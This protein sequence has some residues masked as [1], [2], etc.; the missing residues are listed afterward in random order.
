MEFSRDVCKA[1]LLLC[2]ATSAS[3]TT[4]LCQVISERLVQN[5]IPS[6]EKELEAELLAQ[7]VPEASIDRMLADA[8][9]HRFL[10]EIHRALGSRRS[11]HPAIE[12]YVR[13]FVSLRLPERSLHSLE[14][15]RTGRDQDV[16]IVVQ[17]PRPGEDTVMDHI[18]AQRR[19]LFLRAV[20][21]LFRQGQYDRSLV[22]FPSAENRVTRTMEDL[23]LRLLAAGAFLTTPGVPAVGFSPTRV[24]IAATHRQPIGICRHINA[25]L[26]GIFAE[27]GV[28]VNQI[29]LV[30]GMRFGPG[31]EGRHIWV[32][33]QCEPNG[34]WVE[35]DGTQRA[36]SGTHT[37][38]RERYPYDRNVI[39]DFFSARGQG[40]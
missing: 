15:P 22:G 40:S 38:N 34:P 11:S 36:G 20:A 3:A 16:Q 21:R 6:M 8:V 12:S 13:L 23:R 17:L 35:F 9:T 14:E 24:L 31:E 37:S 7:G 5:P 1:I 32:E 26:A 18:P 25:S 10:E 27:M 39:T 4:R 19:E 28:P 29:R 33:V 2:C 30:S